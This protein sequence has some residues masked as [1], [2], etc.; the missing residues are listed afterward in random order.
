[1]DA[2]TEGTRDKTTAGLYA[3]LEDRILM[4]DQV[5]ASSVY[6]DLVR[7]GRPL[8]EMIAEGVRIH[9]PYTHVPYHERIDDG[10]PNFVN[11]D[12]C[13]LSARATLNLARMLPGKLT[14]LPM[15]QT[16]WYIPSGL[17]I[18]NQKINKAPGHYTRMRG[19]LGSVEGPPAPVVYWPD[20]EPLRT[21]G[22]LKESLNDWQTLVHRGQVID[23]Y[24]LFLGLMEQKEN[25]QEVLAEMCFAGLIDVQD[26]LVWNRSYTT[27]HKAYRARSTVEIGNALGWDNAHNVIYAG[28]LDIAVGPRWYSTYEMA[29]NCVKMWI[30]E[31]QLHAVPYGGVSE[32]ELAVLRNNKEPV[33]Q[34]E[35]AE[36]IRALLQEGEPATLDVLTRLLKSGKDPR[37]IIDVFQIACA[38]IV[39]QTRNPANFNMPHH[40]YE[41]QNTLAWFYDTFDHPR[42]LRLLY[43]AASFLNQVADQQRSLDEVNPIEIPAPSVGAGLSAAQVLDRVDAAICSLNGPDTL[44]WTQAY[45]DAVADRGPLVQRIAIAASKLGN[46]PHNQ[47][48][49]QCMLM[50]FGTNRHPDRDKLLLS[51]AYHTAMHRK[52]G[53]P[54]EPARRLGEA[55]DIA[56]LR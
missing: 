26:R 53:D 18:W 2:R 25:R 40:C 35:A 31:E 22:P 45:C 10:Y 12:H 47:E 4:R 49:A 42:R 33:N 9:A 52:Y 50:D 28:A 23:A 37:R 19:N 15:A 24:R 46:D 29:C 32:A 34:Q 21:S 11:N 8:N 56:A 39:L 20:Q 7:A 55:L 13:L 44:C 54:L 36:L 41:Y 48:I 3:K 38:Q 17:D 14:H 1:M 6:H 43:V 5:G 16:I 51:A 27:G 30:E